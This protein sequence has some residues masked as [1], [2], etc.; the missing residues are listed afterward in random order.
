VLRLHTSKSDVT[1][2]HLQ[3]KYIAQCIEEIKQELRQDNI[4]VKANAVAKLTYVSS[5]PELCAM[6]V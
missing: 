5:M 6:Q 1:I 4:A 2:F 3:A